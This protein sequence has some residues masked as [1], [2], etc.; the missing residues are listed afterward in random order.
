MMETSIGRGGCRGRISLELLSR[1]RTMTVALIC[2]G[3]EEAVVRQEDGR[4][5][6]ETW[7]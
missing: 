4:R 7:K 5:L 6:V 1:G 3:A 2:R